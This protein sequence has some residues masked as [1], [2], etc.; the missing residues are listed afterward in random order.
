[1]SRL[2]IIEE[3]PISVD[4]IE[5]VGARMGY[6]VE[7]LNSLRFVDIPF[8]VERLGGFD[9]IVSEAILPNS[10]G[11]TLFGDLRRRWP[12]TKLVVTSDGSLNDQLRDELFV[13]AL[14]VGAHCTLCKPLL[15]DELSACFS[16]VGGLAA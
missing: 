11:L 1:M 12:Q 8:E 2:L 7:V 13:A 15:D 5:R 3:D 14:Q 16:S 10:N 9:I 6:H 4:I